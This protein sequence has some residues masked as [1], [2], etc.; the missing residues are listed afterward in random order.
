[1]NTSRGALRAMAMSTVAFTVCFACW[2]LNAVLV[3]F[4]VGAGE[5]SFDGTQV[6][7]L[8]ALPILTGA[9]SRVRGGAA[10]GP[11]NPRPTAPGFYRSAGCAGDDQPGG[12]AGDFNGATLSK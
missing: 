1:M 12:L 2:V 4:L 6:G 7:W 9:V 8:L 3:T 10:V 5:L 11:G